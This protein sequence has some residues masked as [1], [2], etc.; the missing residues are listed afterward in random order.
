MKGF[1]SHEDWMKLPF[2]YKVIQTENF[3]KVIRNVI[4]KKVV[5]TD[6]LQ[7]VF[8]NGNFQNKL[9]KKINAELALF[10]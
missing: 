3:P 7:K 2:I 6:N 4:C 1:T 8:R 5:Q 9:I 10:T